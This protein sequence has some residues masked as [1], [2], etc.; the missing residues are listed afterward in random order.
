MA[1]WLIP[2]TLDLDGCGSSLA[3]H[4]LSLDKELYSTLSL[5]CTQVCKMGTGEILLGTTL[6]LASHPGGSSTTPR[7]ASC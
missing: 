1:K 6:Q 7:H 4:F 5:F 3:S 2:Q